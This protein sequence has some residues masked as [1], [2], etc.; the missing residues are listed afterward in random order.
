MRA[1]AWATLAECRLLAGDLD[2]ARQVIAEAWKWNE[3]GTNKPKA[4]VLRRLRGPPAGSTHTDH[5]NRGMS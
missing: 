1:R 5:S 2:G 3:E 4:A